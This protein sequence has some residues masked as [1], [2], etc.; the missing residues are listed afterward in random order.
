MQLFTTSSAIITQLG[1]A[2]Y[3]PAAG[4]NWS[5]SLNTNPLPL[6]KSSS[7]N[8]SLRGM[9][10]LYYGASPSGGNVFSAIVVLKGP[11]APVLVT[12]AT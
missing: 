8:S 6:L 10:L 2:I 3:F 5:D 1:D 9:I 7:Y 4:Y 11:M 12:A